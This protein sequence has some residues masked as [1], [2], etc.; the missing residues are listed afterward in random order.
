MSPAADLAASAASTCGSTWLVTRLWAESRLV[1]AKNATPTTDDEQRDDASEAEVELAPDGEVTGTPRRHG[2]GG[3][4]AMPRTGR[5][6]LLRMDYPSE[7]T[8]VDHA[9]RRARDG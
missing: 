7:V 4:G 3:P 1:I 5:C 6:Q 9:G 8:R 2:G